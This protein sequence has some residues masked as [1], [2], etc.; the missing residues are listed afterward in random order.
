M[1]KEFNAASK[2]DGQAEGQ[3]Q[4]PVDGLGRVKGSDVDLRVSVQE[5]TTV[6]HTGQLKGAAAGGGGGAGVAVVV[7]AP[8]N[9][10]TAAP[11]A[12]A[13][14]VPDATAMAAADEAG[15]REEDM[16]PLLGG[17]PC[18]S[19]G[20]V[21]AGAGARAEVGV[22]AGLGSWVSCALRKTQRASTPPAPPA[23]PGL[24]ASLAD[25]AVDAGSGKLVRV[26]DR[27]QGQVGGCRG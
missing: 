2:E 5:A 24:L 12:T 14:A 9:V 18:C 23:S 13:I 1:L 10:A 19:A 16:Q 22:M 27:E 25:R 7:A 11:D 3:G 15:G 21:L 4:E 20:G 17:G 8:E 26:E 6:G